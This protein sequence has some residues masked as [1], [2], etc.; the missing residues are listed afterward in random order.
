MIAEPVELAAARQ[1]LVDMGIDQ[2]EYEAVR[3]GEHVEIR[4]GRISANLSLAAAE[5]LCKSLRLALY[6]GD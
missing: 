3:R 5:R 1:R 2:P 4:M 6:S